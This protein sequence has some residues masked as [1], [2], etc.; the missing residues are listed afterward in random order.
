MTKFKQ[1]DVVRRTGHGITA[2]YRGMHIGDVDTVANATGSLHLAKFGGGH[3][4]AYF[5]LVCDDPLPDVPRD[6]AYNQ[7]ID[8]HTLTVRALAANKT[9]RGRLVIGLPGICTVLTPDDALNLC[10]DLRRM[11][12][13]IKRQDEKDA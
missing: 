4:P 13:E 2:N 8:A 12:M 9:Y 11:A 5:E 1:G 10:H 7:G 6:V 3:D